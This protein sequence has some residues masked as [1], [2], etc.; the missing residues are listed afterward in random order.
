MVQTEKHR[1]INELHSRFS[2]FVNSCMDKGIKA[3][4]KLDIMHDIR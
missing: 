4:K 1:I 3:G 2:F